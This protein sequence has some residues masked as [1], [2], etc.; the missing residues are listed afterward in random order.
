MRTDVPSDTNE[1]HAFVG[2]KACSIAGSDIVFA[3]ASLERDDGHQMAASKD[4]DVLDEA[5]V[6]W[7]KGSR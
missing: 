5:I 3:L 4:G 6:Q 2:M 7:A 1:H